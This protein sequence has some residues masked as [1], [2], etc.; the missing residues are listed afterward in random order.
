EYKFE[1]QIFV[2][3]LSMDKRLARPATEMKYM[4]LP[5]RQAVSRD[6]SV[7]IPKRIEYAE[8]VEAINGLGIKELVSVRLFDLYTGKNL[9]EDRQSLSLNLRYQPGSESMTDQQ[10]NELDER[11]VNMLTTRFEAQLRR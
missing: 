8:I 11:I 2:A 6:I 7:L 5:K 3:E 1:Q 10:I 9:P 4:P